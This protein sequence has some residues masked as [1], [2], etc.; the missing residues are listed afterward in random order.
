MPRRPRIDFPGAWHHVMH[1]GARRSPVFKKDAHCHLFLDLLEDA[2]REFELQVHAYSLMPN[3][4]HL[5]VRSLHGNLSRAMKRLDA[6][7]TQ[8][9]NLAQGWD[10]PVFRGRFRS[11]LIEDESSL[12]YVMAYIHLNP[13]KAGLITRLQSH[14]WTS[15]RAYLGLDEKPWLTTAHFLAL[16]GDPEAL[17][18]YVR[19]LH[20]GKL[21]WPERMVADSG[22]LRPTGGRHAMR[23]REMGPTRFL[24]P[25][26]AL[27]RISAVTGSELADLRSVVLGPRA[28]PARRFAVWALKDRTQLTHAEI[29]TLLGMSTEQVSHVLRRISMREEPM[30]GWYAE[31]LDG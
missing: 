2:A 10:G 28:N 24:D 5:L 27:A 18:R 25:E 17:H 15:H 21:A 13:L 9:V 6:T 11:E 23:P 22:W 3:H 16:F 1:R 8:R 29:G 26:V 30:A 20:R 7:Y 31:W 19:D 4:Y 12:P 14:G